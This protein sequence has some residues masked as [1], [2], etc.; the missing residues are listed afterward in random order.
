MFW[1]FL[2]KGRRKV[3]ELF[4]RHWGRGFHLVLASFQKSQNCRT[5]M[6]GQE[7]DALQRRRF[8]SAA[9]SRDT[10]RL[11]TRS[12]AP[13]L[14]LLRSPTQKDSLADSRISMLC[15]CISYLR[16]KKKKK[17]ETLAAAEPS[18]P[19]D[20]IEIRLPFCHFFFPSFT[21]NV[22]PYNFD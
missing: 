12:G 4:G 17:R 11:L 7:G 15:V 16:K 14:G 19:F 20:V 21:T 22:C 2:E 13:F 1:V 18:V 3:E 10:L 6:G 9:H 8:S 5:L